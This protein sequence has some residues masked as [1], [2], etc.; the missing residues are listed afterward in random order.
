MQLKQT[1]TGSPYWMA[2]DV[3]LQ[4]QYDNKVDIWSLGITA[5]E[6]AETQPPYSNHIPMSALFL[7]AAG[8]RRHPGLS[9]KDKWS[10]KFHDFIEVCLER[11]KERRPASAKIIEHQFCLT[12][13]ESQL[14]V[15][16]MVVTITGTE[17][18]KRRSY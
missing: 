17:E 4:E 16:N 2:P 9:E 3:I 10:P 18:K 14:E 6:L 7:I 15:S 5:I 1:A 11:D 8:D 12:E 13:T